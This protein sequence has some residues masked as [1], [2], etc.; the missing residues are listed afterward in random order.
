MYLRNSWYVAAWDHE[1]DS[2]LVPIKVLG[3]AIVLYRKTDGVVV[4]LE[5]AC[6]PSKTSIVDGPD[7]R[8]RC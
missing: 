8:R 3:E 2:G 5:D 4:A 6:P 7:K 1:V